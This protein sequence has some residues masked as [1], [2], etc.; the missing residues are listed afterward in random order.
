MKET[1]SLPKLS[2]C[3]CIVRNDKQM[4]HVICIYKMIFNLLN[5]NIANHGFRLLNL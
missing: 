3:V 5:L 2:H 4:F 1:V